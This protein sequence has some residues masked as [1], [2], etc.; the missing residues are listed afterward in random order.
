MKS[1]ANLKC[2]ENNPQ[3]KENFHKNKVAKDGLCRLCKI[4]ARIERKSHYL[5]NKQITLKNNKNYVLKNKQFVENYKKHWSKENGSRIYLNRKNNIQTRLATALRIRLLSA[6]KGNFKK[7]S[8][9]DALGCSIFE[10]KIYLESKFTP[11]MSWK[12]YGQKGW[13]IDHIVPLSLFDL[14]NVEDLNKA[15]HYT[16]LQPMWWRENIIKSNKL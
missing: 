13:H 2:I 3:K 7:G 6:L 9:I 10:L 1:C 16:N 14:T 15:C 8:A 12:N 11:G 5:K 4:C